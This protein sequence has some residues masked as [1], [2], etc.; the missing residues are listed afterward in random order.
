MD[1]KFTQLLWNLW[2]D[3]QPPLTKEQIEEF[4][5]NNDYKINNN[6]RP[7]KNWY[8]CTII[9]ANEIKSNGNLIECLRCLFDNG[10]NSDK[11]Y[12]T[13]NILN[14][15][16]NFSDLIT[17]VELLEENGDKISKEQLLAIALTEKNAKLFDYLIKNELVDLSKCVECLYIAIRRKDMTLVKFFVENGV[18]VNAKNPDNEVMRVD[19]FYPVLAAAKTQNYE[20]TEYLFKKGADVELFKPFHYVAVAGKFMDDFKFYSL[21]MDYG[22]SDEWMECHP[23]AY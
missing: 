9:K 17:L 22:G 1:E 12:E 5:T 3:D 2:K 14:L 13:A 6:Y 8:E 21:Y 10:M 19:D 20:I 7:I 15:N 11:E 23:Y 16:V 4:I 18:D